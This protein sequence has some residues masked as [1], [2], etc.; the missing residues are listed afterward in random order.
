LRE[1]I[2]PPTRTVE[3][4]TPIHMPTIAGLSHGV[5]VA[6]RYETPVVDVRA[7]KRAELEL[8]AAELEEI[9]ARDAL[10][11][12]ERRLRDVRHEARE[13]LLP[14]SDARVNAALAHFAK[15]LVRAAENMQRLHDVILPEENARLGRDEHGAERFSAQELVFVPVA[16]RASA[17]VAGGLL[18]PVRARTDCVNDQGEWWWGASWRPFVAPGQIRARFAPLWGVAPALCHAR[19]SFEGEDVTWRAR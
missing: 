8:P 18:V 10:D 16:A 1:V 6:T 5:H 3:E 9:N 13:R 19:A 12:L 4:R 2:N 11:V 14:G 15:D 17:R 7:M